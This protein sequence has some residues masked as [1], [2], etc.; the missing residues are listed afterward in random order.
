VS[1]K[2][3]RQSNNDGASSEEENEKEAIDG[4]SDMENNESYSEQ[5]EVSSNFLEVQL[6]R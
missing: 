2:S 5:Q 6:W 3:K 4:D 1:N